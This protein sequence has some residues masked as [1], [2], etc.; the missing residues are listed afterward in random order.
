MQR[1]QLRILLGVRFPARMSNEDTHRISEEPPISIQ[2]VEARW[3]NL[4]HILRRH[5]DRPA[6]KS[7]R[8]FFVKKEH[9]DQDARTASNRSRLL[10]T[11]PRILQ[12]LS[13][14]SEAERRDAFAIIKLTTS[15][16]LAT[17]QNKA[18]NRGG[19]RRGVEKIVAAAVADCWRDRQGYRKERQANVAAMRGPERDAPANTRPVTRRQTTLNEHFLRR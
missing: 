2:I 6:N 7:M 16:D 14:L 9:Q 18:Q 4:G 12:N 17:L 13:K 10:T 11:I 8:K 15:S 5:G 3:T 1:R 19:W